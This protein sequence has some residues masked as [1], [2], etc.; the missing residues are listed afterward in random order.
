MGAKI[1]GSPWRAAL[2]KVGRAAAND[3]PDRTD[4]GRDQ[5]AVRE[6]ADPLGEIDLILQK[7]SLATRSAIMIRISISR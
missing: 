5:A 6:F 1:A 7:V 3:A 2:G 4:P